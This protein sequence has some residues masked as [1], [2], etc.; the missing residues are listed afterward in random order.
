MLPI[1]KSTATSGKTDLLTGETS[2]VWEC[3]GNWFTLYLREGST[4]ANGFHAS[5]LSLLSCPIRDGTFNAHVV[6]NETGTPTAQ[7]FTDGSENLLHVFIAP[8]MFFKLSM[9][10]ANTPNIDAWVDG[11]VVKIH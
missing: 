6:K 9:E 7:V 11:P 3:V 4:N 2:R 1:P 10:A 5:D 8:G